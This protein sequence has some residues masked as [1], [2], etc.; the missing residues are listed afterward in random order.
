MNFHLL[1]SL[2]RTQTDAPNAMA[3]AHKVLNPSHPNLMKTP[4][5]MERYERKNK[6]NLQRTP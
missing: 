1:E 5:A 3:R 6:V 2:G 4:N